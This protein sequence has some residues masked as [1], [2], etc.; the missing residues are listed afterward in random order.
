M[1]C[2]FQIFSPNIECDNNETELIKCER[3]TKPKLEF[4]NISDNVF[5]NSEYDLI[6]MRCGL[7][8]DIEKFK[9][10][11]ICSNHRNRLGLFNFI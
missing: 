2:D 10:F 8:P 7:M 4:L 11:S 5:S 9:L 6:L 3:D 1:C